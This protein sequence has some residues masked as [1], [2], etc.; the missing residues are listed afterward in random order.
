MALISSNNP[1]LDNILDHAYEAYTDRLLEEAYGDHGECCKVCKHFCRAWKGDPNNYCE[2][3]DN[4]DGEYY[5]I[6]QPHWCCDD[7]EWAD[8]EPEVDY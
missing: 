6:T 5:E 2:K 3:H 1:N 8:N 7:F 4:E